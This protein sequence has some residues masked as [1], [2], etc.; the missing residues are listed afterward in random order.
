MKNDEKILRDASGHECY[1]CKLCTSNDEKL[2]RKNQK[3]YEACE[4]LSLCPPCYNIHAK[5]GIK[6]NFALNEDQENFF[7]QT[8]AESEVDQADKDTRC[9]SSLLQSKTDPI[10]Y[11]QLLN[12]ER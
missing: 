9:Q 3:G 12:F 4:K 2:I 11:S 1:I 5:D 7:D 8:A 6:K 10:V